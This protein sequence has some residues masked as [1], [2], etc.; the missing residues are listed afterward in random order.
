MSK[1]KV[2]EVDIRNGRFKLCETFDCARLP[3][4]PMSVE[5]HGFEFINF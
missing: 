4:I 3:M 2:E 1:E 5:M